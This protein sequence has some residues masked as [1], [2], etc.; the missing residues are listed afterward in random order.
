M[1]KTAKMK[2]NFL[3]KIYYWKF[4][5]TINRNCL[6]HLKNQQSLQLLHLYLVS[7]TLYV[8]SLSPTCMYTQYNIR[9]SSDWTFIL[10]VWPD[11]NMSI[12]LINRLQKGKQN[13]DAIRKLEIYSRFL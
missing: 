9:L 12:L 8:P 10:V 4:A 11:I 13:P 3:I 1:K 6:S 2:Q 7:N 5:L